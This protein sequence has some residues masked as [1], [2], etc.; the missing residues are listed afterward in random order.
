MD[1]AANERSGHGGGVV[2]KEEKGYEE[3]CSKE[4]TAVIKV[5]L[6]FFFFFSWKFYC[7]LI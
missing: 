4:E 5:E 7:G 3:G 1:A 2:L 6:N